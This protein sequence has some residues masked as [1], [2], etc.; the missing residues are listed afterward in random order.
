MM[1]ALACHPLGTT[2]YVMV[3]TRRL[4]EILIRLDRYNQSSNATVKESESTR[5]KF[6]AYAWSRFNPF[7]CYFQPILSFHSADLL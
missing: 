6:W 1:E 2:L 7:H 5:S 4:S 3:Y